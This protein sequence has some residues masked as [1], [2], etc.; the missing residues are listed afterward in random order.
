[1]FHIAMQ[2]NIVLSLAK[3]MARLAMPAG[4][5]LTRVQALFLVICSISMVMAASRQLQ[6]STSLQG[7]QITGLWNAACAPA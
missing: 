6:Q 7:H 5:E 4:Q 2:V 3:T 1:M